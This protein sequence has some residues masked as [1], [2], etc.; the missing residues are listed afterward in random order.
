MRKLFV[1]SVLSAVLTVVTPIW[2]QGKS[3]TAPGQLKKVQVTQ[4]TQKDISGTNKQIQATIGGQIGKQI[5]KFKPAKPKLGLDKLKNILKLIATDSGSASEAAKGKKQNKL[6]VKIA[7]VSAQLKRRAVQGVITNIA[8]D[9]LTISHQIQQDRVYLVL[10][11]N[12]TF[13]KIKQTVATGSAS[14]SNLAVGQR[15]VAVGDLGANGE[16]I[17][18]KIHVIPGKAIGVIKK[19]PIATSSPT[20]K[21]SPG[22]TATLSATP[23]VKVSPTE[24]ISPTGL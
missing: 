20:L 24:V 17:A 3:D 19:Q 1:F 13:I 8:G 23:A 6:K 2:A 16:I 12:E 9:L 4:S 5:P 11:T 14:I 10:V 7:T 15:I 21:S 18:K 22:P